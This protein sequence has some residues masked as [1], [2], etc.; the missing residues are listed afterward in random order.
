MLLAVYSFLIAL[1]VK[2]VSEEYFTSETGKA[3]IRRL[4]IQFKTHVLGYAM[5]QTLNAPNIG[6][7]SEVEFQRHQTGKSKKALKQTRFST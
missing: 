5:E 4:G 7:C 2:S 3:T 1:W 6:Y